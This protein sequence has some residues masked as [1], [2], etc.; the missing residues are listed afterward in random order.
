MLLDLTVLD[1][2]LSMSNGRGT[3]YN[4]YPIRFRSQI[5][6]RT[7]QKYTQTTLEEYIDFEVVTSII[8]IGWVVVS[9]C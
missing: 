2:H 4:K 8:N 1:L 9:W 3:L 6:F 5:T 7:Y